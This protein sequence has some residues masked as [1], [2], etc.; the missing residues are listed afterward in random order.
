MI[1]K[2]KRRLQMGLETLQGDRPQGF[3]TPYRYADQVTA[4][5]GYPE[6]ENLFKSARP[7]IE[8][9]LDRIDAM[10]DRLAA[11]DGAPPRPRWG[12]SWFPRLDGAAA[13]AMVNISKP[14]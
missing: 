5:T 3:F 6:L 10:G 12:Q 1:D 8:A 2:E 4:P 11:L 9:V 13:I 7:S 14:R